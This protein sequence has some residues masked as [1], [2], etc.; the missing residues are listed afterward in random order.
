M[1]AKRYRQTEI[2]KIR[3]DWEVVKAMRNGE[4][5]IEVY[6]DEQINE[7]FICLGCL[8]IPIDKKEQL[9]E[10]LSNMRC[11]SNEN[12][13]WHWKHQDCPISNMCRWHKYN[14][15]QIH[16]TELRNNSSNAVKEISKKWL[17]FLINHNKKDG[18]EIYFNLLYINLDNL[19]ISKF[20][21]EKEHE[22]IYNRFFRTSLD[23][24]I[25]TF[26]SGS[27]VLIKR[28]YHDQ[29]SIQKHKYF[30]YLNLKKLE[31]LNSDK[32]TIEDYTIKFLDSNH[33]SYIDQEEN[34]VNECQ[35]LQFIDLIMGATTQNIY[36]P[37]NNQFKKELATIIRPL[38]ERLLK[39]PCNKNS[40]YHYYQKQNISFFPNDKIQNA[41]QITLYGD[42]MEKYGEEFYRT[43][44]LKMLYYHPQQQKLSL[45]SN[46]N[47]SKI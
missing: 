6:A 38:V 9:V 11:L 4:K 27:K 39:S 23:Y 34:F 17:N 13:V 10:K 16:H 32:I 43:P 15:G 18:K 3:E 45:Q 1:S 20:G 8:F 30:P 14:N 25:K 35:L 7:H 42:P 5:Y 28:V 44:K 36:Y 31:K 26:F 24:G 29:A 12:K 19:D 33:N 47:E 2:G 37:S 46:E 21:S 41:I 40:S 22:N